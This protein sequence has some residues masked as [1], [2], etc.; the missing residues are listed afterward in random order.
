MLSVRNVILISLA[1][2][3]LSVAAATFALMGP[4]DS[5]GA[6]ADSYGTLREGHRAVYELLAEMQ[7]PV[8]RR[9]EPP[10]PDLSDDATIILW[11]PHDDLVANEPSYLQQ[12]IP[13][14]ERGGRL[15]VAVPPAERGGPFKQAQLKMREKLVD[16]FDALNLDGVRV[17]STAPNQSDDRRER[18]R[19]S[20]EELAG[21]HEFRFTMVGP[22]LTGSF[23]S[24]KD[25]V[26]TLEIP[27]E[28]VGGLEIDKFADASGTIQYSLRGGKRWTLAARF[29]RGKGEIVVVGEP[30]LLMNASLA[31]SD[32]AVLAFDLLANG[33]SMV[34][35]D[36][37][38]HGLSVR[39]NVLWL[40]TK[41]TYSLVAFALAGLVALELWRRAALLGPPLNATSKSRRTI[42]EYIEAMGHF[43]N[44]SR[45]CR[46]FLLNEVRQGSLRLIGE[47][48]GLPAAA[49]D[50]IKI[51]VSLEKVSP[52]DAQ[53]FR[54]AMQDVD[55]AL[56]EGSSLS[57]RQA[58]LALQRISRCL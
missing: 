18:L 54:Q 55:A 19:R 48:L 8:Q 41:S 33:R 10:T 32:N 2:L 24:S 29:P 22:A 20:F 4:P 21:L 28:N 26:R 16:I 11:M 3:L 51:G 50:V 14:I 37:F 23:E 40:L 52:R 45:G 36:E 43:L 12:L 49:H 47:R 44:R 5:G 17:I 25:R 56:A 9:I 58:V 15:V 57:E 39:G 42:L 38:Y 7:V 31:K 13:W 53:R 27:L 6:A 46:H 35:F 34:V 30:L 1:T